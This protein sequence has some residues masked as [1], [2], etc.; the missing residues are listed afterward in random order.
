[1]VIVGN[2]SLVLADMGKSDPHYERL[3]NIDDLSK[4]G[5]ELTHQLLGFARGGKYQVKPTNLNDLVTK[6]MN[7]FGRTRKEIEIHFDFEEEIWAVEVDRGQIEQVLLN[8]CVNASQAMPGGGR[9]VVRTQNVVFQKVLGNPLRVNPGEYVKLSMTDNGMGMDE[10]IRKRIFEPF[11]T[12]KE[13]G[14]GTGLGLATV[15]GIIKSH[16]GQIQVDSKK[17]EGTTFDVFL[18]STGQPIQEKPQEVLEEISGRETVLIVDDEE[19]VLEVGGQMLEHLGYKVL[20]ARDGQTATD[21]LRQ[22]IGAIDL[23]ILDMIMPKLSGGQTF[24]RLHAIDPNAKVLLS[25]GYSI[26]GEA[27]EILSRGCSGFIQKPFDMAQLSR[28]VRELLD[29]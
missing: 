8:L 17:G 3:K 18:P 11:F 28:K 5:A 25:S 12:T 9:L 24:D 29:G 10:D 2:T 14:R 4:S 23:I 7:T 6:N 16:G 1:M 26:N 15:Y 13:M 21:I 20:S 19:M 22:N 27:S